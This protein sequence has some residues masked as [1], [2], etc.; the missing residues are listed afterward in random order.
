MI[1]CLQAAVQAGVLDKLTPMLWSQ[2]SL[3]LTACLMLL[4]V[5]AVKLPQEQAELR[6]TAMLGAGFIIRI[7]TILQQVCCTQLFFASSS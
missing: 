4:H 3:E 5:L 7:F 1:C 2:E 6:L